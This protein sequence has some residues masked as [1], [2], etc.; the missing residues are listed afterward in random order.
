M[1]CIVC[2]CLVLF[3][4]VCD[5]FVGLIVKV[6]LLLFDCVD[7]YC[8]NCFKLIFDVIVSLLFVL[9]LLWLFMF[10]YW[11]GLHVLL[12]WWIVVWFASV[13]WFDCF[14]YVWLVLYYFRFD[15]FMIGEVLLLLFRWFY[16]V[17]IYAAV[18]VVMMC[19]YD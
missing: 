10:C 3:C 5:D 6:D 4:F 1:V 11:C 8:F 2:G 17:V 9:I 7:L 19:C 13:V 15:A 16:L 14:A 12:F 18:W